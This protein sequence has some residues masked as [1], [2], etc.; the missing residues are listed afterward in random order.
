MFIFASLAD[1]KLNHF[2][3]DRGEVIMRGKRVFK[4]LLT[5]LLFV[6]FQ[7][8][9]AQLSVSTTPAL[10]GNTVFLCLDDGN[11]I[12]YT[13]NYTGA[14]D[15]IIWTLTG[16][17]LSS[18]AGAGSFNVTYAATG[19]FQ[20]L[21]NVYFMDSVIASRN[22][23]VEVNQLN[24]PTFTVPDTVCESD[25]P[26]NLTGTPPGGT[27]SGPGV[28][29]NTFDPDAAN[30]GQH[31]LTYTVTAGACTETTTRDIYVN[32]APEPVLRANGFGTPWQGR[33]TYSSCDS[34]SNTSTFT[35]Y[36][37]SLATNYSSYNLD[38]GDGSATVSG[39]VFPN[40]LGAG[41]SH[42]YVGA[43]LY[44]VALTLNHSNGCSRTD[45]IN[46]FIGQQPAIGFSIPGGTINQCIP[47]DSGYI[48]IC[49]AVT[50]VAGNNP[51]TVYTLSSNDGSPD[52]VFSHPP[53][54]TVCH[55]FML[56]SCGFNSSKFNNAFELSFRASNP[57][58]ERSSTVEPIYISAPSFA[59]F[60]NE[61]DACVNQ[62][63][64]IQD[65]SLEGGIVR[66]GVCFED[67]KT[68]WAISPSTYTVVGGAASLGSTFGSPDPINWISGA[69]PLDVTFHQT[70]LYTIQQVVGNAQECTNDTNTRV[71]CIDS[72]PVADFVLSDDTICSGESVLASFVGNIQSVC[73]TLDLQWRVL[74][75]SGY[76][77]GPTGALDTT[78]SITFTSSGIYVVELRAGNN[79][80]TVVVTDTLVVQ[81]IP[82]MVMPGDTVVCS[83]TTLDFGDSLLAPVIQDSLAPIINYQW[84]VTPA[85]G[86]SFLNATTASDSQPVIQFT[87]HGNYIISH[88]VTNACGSF[89]DSMNVQ[90]L[91]RPQLDSIADTL[92]CY[93]DGLVIRA[94]ASLGLLPY[95]FEWTIN[96]QGVV[97]TNDSLVLA[98]LTTDT[99][100]Q[101]EVTDA[102]GCTDSLT[103]TV[104]VAPE[105]IVN[106]GNDQSICYSDTTS[107]NATVSGG[108][109]PYTIVWSPSTGLSDSTVL[110]PSRSALDSTVVYY[111][112]ITDSLGCTVEDS[113]EIEVFPLANLQIDNDTS[114]CLNGG[115]YTFMANP[116]GGSWSGTG[117]NAGGTFD[118]LVAGVG[119]YTL[120]YNYTDA[121][122]CDYA[123]SLTVSVVLQ[124]SVGFDIV[125]DTA[126]CSVLQVVVTDSS[127]NPGNWFI[128]NQPVALGS[129]DT[130]NLV[131]LSNQNDSIVTIKREVQAGSG[132]SDSTVRQVVI[133][134]R[135]LA[136]FDLGS[137]CA[138]D[139]VQVSNNSIFKGA[140]A[141]YNW[142]VPASVF[143]DDTTAFEPRLA[144]PDNNSGTDSSYT[145][146]L[147]V[148]SVDGCLDTLVQSVT[149]PSR[150][151]AQFTIPTAACGP[152][153]LSPADSSL[154]NQLSY[155]WSVSPSAGVNINN[156]SASNPIIDFPVSVNNSVVYTLTL[157]VVDSAGC[158]DSTSRVFTVYP[159]PVAAFGFSPQDSCSPYTVN[160]QNTSQTSVPG[161]GLATLN[162]MWDFGN[163]QTSTDSLP[164]V[165]FTNSGTVDSTYIV[166]LAI[167]NSLGC[168]DTVTDS[169]TVHPDARAIFNPE[170]TIGCAPFTLLG[171]S[172]NVQPFPVANAS[173]QW[174]VLD[175][176]NRNVVQSFSG[177][178]ALNYTI[179]NY[180][181]SVLVQLVAISA[182]GCQNDT[183]EQL[184]QTVED[185]SPFFFLNTDE[186]CGDTLVVTVDSV[187]T[188]PGL[189]Y[190]WFVNGI[191]SSSAAQ[192]T[193]LLINS[194]QS[195]LDFE[196]RLDITVGTNGC[197][198]SVLDS[199]R[200]L[201]QPVAGFSFGSVCA[202]DTVSVTNN[203]IFKG[204]AAAYAWTVP[205]N[206][207]VSDSSLTQPDFYFPDAQ[208]AG[209]SVYTIVL[210]VTSVDGCTHSS[211]QN[212]S[213]HNRPLAAFGLPA[214]GCSPQTVSPSDSS[215]G[216]G[217]NYQWSVSPAAGVT[218]SGAT[219]A[220]PVIDFPLTTS[221]S[222]VYAIRLDLL[223]SD[224]C[225]DS[226]VRAFTVYPK[227]TAAFSFSP[228][229]SCGP[230]QITF[231]NQ[232]F[233]GQNG[234]PRDS[235]S[236]DWNFGNG[237][238]STDSVPTVTFTNSGT[239]DSTFFIRLIATNPFGCADTVVDLVTVHPNPVALFAPN[240][241][242][243]CAPF[244]ILGDSLNVSQF[245]QAN[246]SY[247]WN[248]LNPTNRNLIQSFNGISNLNYTLADYDDSV[249]VQLVVQSPFGCRSDTAE[250]LFKTVEDPS[251]FFV[252]STYEGCGD[253]L[254]VSVDSVV[255]GSGIQYEWY[256]N[257]VLSS[258]SGNPTFIFPN[259]GTS[260]LIFDIRLEVSVGS[261]ACRNT[262]S[263]TVTVFARP[264]A[265]WS[266]APVCFNDST[267]FT[268]ATTTTDVI[269]AWAWDFGDG[270]TSTQANPV[271]VYTNPGTY[272][273]SLTATDSRGCSDVSMD[274]VTVY[275]LPVADFSIDTASCGQDTS[276]VGLTV[277]FH[278]LSTL[279]PD[280]GIIQSRE[281][282]FDNDGVVDAT[283][284]DPTF[285]YSNTGTYNVSLRIESQF[286]CI[287]TLSKTLVILDPPDA[288][289]TADTVSNCGPLNITFQDQSSGFITQQS[290][291]VFSFTPSGNRVLIDSVTTGGNYTP[292]DFVSNYR[293]DTTYYI[294]QTVR[295]CCGVFSHLDSII[296]KPYPVAGFSF[297]K[298]SL[299]SNEVNFLL[300]GRSL[301]NPDSVTI[302][303]GDGSSTSVLPRNTTVHPYTWPVV[304]HSFPASS[305]GSVSFWVSLTAYNECGDSTYSDSVTIEAKDLQAFFA[306]DTQQNC[307]NQPIQFYDQSFASVQPVKWC[308]DYNPA[309]GICNTALLTGDTVSFTYTA[310]G[311]YTIANFITG[312]CDKD[313]STL[314]ITVN[315][316]PTAGFTLSNN[317]VCENESI[318]FTNQSTV[319]T[320]FQPVYLW[321][322]GDGT[323]SSLVNPQ[324]TYTDNG[325]YGVCLTV[326]YGNG[327]DHTVCDTVI[328]HDI[329]TVDFSVEAACA[330]DSV[331]LYDST[332]V[333]NGSIAQSIWK[334]DS[335]GLFFNNP[336][337][338]IFDYP[339]SY[340]I[341][342][343]Q[344]STAGCID[345]ATQ[346]LTIAE[347]PRAF[348]TVSP[349]TT[350][351]SCGNSTAFYFRDSSL[352]SVPL[353]YLW[354][355]D[356][357][358]PG[359]LTSSLRNPGLRAFPDTGYFYIQ[360]SVWNADSCWD[361]RIDTLFV[362][363]NS[364][365]DFSPRNPM[366]CMGDE[367]QFYDSTS[368]RQGSGNNELR[369]FWDFGDGNT[370]M[371]RNPAHTYDSAGTYFVKLVV[372][373]P[374]CLDSLIR[375]VTIHQVPEASIQPGNYEI[376]AEDVITISATSLMQFPNGDRIDSLIWSVSDGRELRVFRDTAI[377]I[378]F[379]EQGDYQLGLRVVTDKGCSDTADARVSIRVYPTPDVL[380]SKNQVAKLD[381]RTFAFNPLIENTLEPEYKWTFGNRDSIVSDRISLPQNYIYDD[382]LCRID[383]DLNYIVGLT[384][385][386]RIE[387][388]GDC[389]GLDTTQIEMQ[390]YHLNV[391]NAFAPGYGGFGEANI[392]LPK[393][394]QLGSYH[395]WIH[396]EWG[397][398]LF[399]S[400]LLDENGSPAEHWDGTFQGEQ[401]P[402][403]AYAWHIEAYFNDGREWPSEECGDFKIV[404][405]GTVTLIR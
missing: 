198:R 250:Q 163:G 300:S 204:A 17:S 180:N 61:P 254:V 157:N 18:F 222:A 8:M 396:D 338:L 269:A 302:D 88:T 384:V 12:S 95:S 100:I 173:Y 80:D 328:I 23:N 106:A 59:G 62:S 238:N 160:F 310:A 174:N 118:P 33:L 83:F 369:Y 280:G 248:V 344:E 117:V 301:G 21:V 247:T 277:Q 177:I 375:P 331:F 341:T 195:D 133:Y 296:L 207:Y 188:S 329:P 28:S 164:S 142:Q 394:R 187:I 48:E 333:V 15:S 231:A 235:M 392:F 30:P 276:C 279:N 208:G 124:P 51:E 244:T 136:A 92:L 64:L 77:F 143:I 325:E 91:Q 367:I 179:S 68:I 72:I 241:T 274:S 297:N 211:I 103:F 361:S 239:I 197:G 46:V 54:D 268:N 322:F 320:S 36:N 86:W 327:C 237:F 267:V 335:Q 126:G 40:N 265:V 212:I 114:L 286:G 184:F 292:P 32:D 150:P 236:F 293:N 266:T 303:F 264:D 339:G 378:F 376:C 81:G 41:I 194:G 350:V 323:G 5:F 65:T 137:F 156:G 400:T 225:V 251:P 272:L 359:T 271:H 131:N 213:I 119:N 53:P 60:E 104:N 402:M 373:D 166:Q 145:L 202:G 63:V 47:R 82:S 298:D 389:I 358:N 13:A 109:A 306:V 403:G 127:G 245:P 305:T 226:L 37:Q 246:S 313:T 192:P 368:Y 151:R 349:D 71:I 186:G 386:N 219:S 324:H 233:S 259:N 34:V 230:L 282:D 152:L 203:S 134:P 74:Q 112:R 123:D 210:L 128:N 199:V 351:D 387:G 257:N 75:P 19:S 99:V 162:I 14:N 372:Q 107:L 304:A 31:T 183:V 189:Q 110:N 360:L 102:L 326:T 16:G 159:K 229:D 161:E 146:Q 22:L 84:T 321:S 379:E 170:D 314:Q 78:Q 382:R 175:P 70:G 281:W 169:V 283:S 288:L 275:P 309:T 138:G 1:P 20:A 273:V 307:V 261:L 76:F 398:L 154:G 182:F 55:R 291:S 299:C 44:E 39:A 240:D 342:L 220:N 397:N 390:G 242:V 355:F 364:R 27:F 260:D 311:N 206:V 25:A 3:N 98:S 132:C 185:P 115:S 377:D 337:P 125:G 85:T 370:S 181:D 29:N 315:P 130:L 284:T 176:V 224:G 9:Q 232:S 149:V 66:N 388:F 178:S 318:Q 4:V 221:D 121:F 347:V 346:T 200:V 90:I 10:Q 122:G 362:P 105:L 319:A 111:V 252:L 93:N 343:I 191:A 89:T 79:C 278:D 2:R 330:G 144:F 227:P 165:T 120:N 294:L 24:V 190:E 308:L 56:S 354:D 87:Q 35:F 223:N 171:D 380:L 153:S 348:F 158:V 385:I 217:L 67:G 168:S 383:Y 255:S 52:V 218:I 371:Q 141:S 113:V 262:V 201:P 374:F 101:L 49:V 270:D 258:S 289:F 38:F 243:S 395:L 209:D 97:S 285:V 147:L 50:G 167:T 316:S 205:A 249:L 129:T 357:A 140:A 393:G 116:A 42:Q 340:N 58:S 172:M 193:F 96:G 381:A 69:N 287:D 366:A 399:E 334:V 405:Y 57:C 353:Q 214:R 332:Q 253:T 215:V 404:D 345:S 139:T 401:M 365:V 43:G 263:D 256:V 363:P 216:T 317:E 228:A 135:P 352:S 73:Q 356:L 45:T 234:I 391:P 155:N 290:W 94:N 312:A 26:L 148:T 11:T 336:S 108:T 7:K 6:F 295:N 196:I